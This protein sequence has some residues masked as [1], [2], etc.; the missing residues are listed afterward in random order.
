MKE[1]HKTTLVRRN[2][3]G[4]MAGL[5]KI[6][7]HIHYREIK[8]WCKINLPAGAWQSYIEGETGKKIFL[9][10]EPKYQTLFLLRWANECRL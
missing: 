10:K 7:N 5:E 2:L 3:Y 6:G 1:W 8:E 4:W 9:F